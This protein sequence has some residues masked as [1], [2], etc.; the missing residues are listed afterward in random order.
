MNH[1]LLLVLTLLLACIGMMAVGKPRVEVVALIALLLLPLLGLV[2]V[3]QALAGFSDPNV[4]LIAL[5]FV[6]GEGLVRTG[7]ALRLSEW[8]LARAGESE[9]RV[10]VLL[11]LAVSSLGAFMSSTGVVAIFLPVALSVA[12]RL[13]IHPGR[14]M[15]PLSF[16][17]LSSGMLTLVGTPP[18]MVL[19]SALDRA[20]LEGFGFFSFTPVGLTLLGLGIVYMLLVRRWLGTSS[21]APSTGSVRRGFREL[22]AAYRIDGRGH[23]LRVTATSPMVGQTLEKLALRRQYQL[24]VLGVKRQGPF[25]KELLSP[26]GQ[27]AL[28]AGDILLV[29]TPGELVST[30]ELGLEETPFRGSYLTDQTHEVGMAEVML[31]PDSELVGKTIRQATFRTVHGVNVVG[32]RRGGAP[33]EGDYLDEPLRVADTLLVVGVWKSIRQLQI[34]HRDFVVLSLPAEADTVAPALDRAPLALVSLGVMVALMV[35]GIV[36]YVLAA[37]I[38][39]LLMGL[40]GCIDV[41]SSLKSIHWPSLLLIVGLMPFAQALQETGGVELGVEG[42]L[43]LVGDS[44]PIVLLGALFLLTAAVNMFISN[45]ATAVLMAPVALSMASQV[46]TS[47]RP[48]AM[49]V[50]IAASAAFMTPVSSPVNTLVWGPGQ[51][52]FFDFVKVGVPFTAIVLVVTL[53]LVPWLFPFHPVAPGA[54]PP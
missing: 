12:R 30:A 9:S 42:L 19:S 26:S 6:V 23:S 32:L 28:R 7:V 24:N 20:E 5:I 18:N 49:T 44:G 4:I 47:A 22:I 13:E 29:D 17:G 40:F 41:E 43:S 3:P 31:H 52:R 36:P 33:F 37:L 11:M 10:I 48:F 21:S 25:G 27:L 34:H 15:M 1:D 51:Y 35:S 8:L 14:L 53:L 39:C 45:T 16:A 54:V 2:S 50:A 38:A 46:G